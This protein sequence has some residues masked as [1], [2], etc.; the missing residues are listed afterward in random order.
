[1]NTHRTANLALKCL[2]VIFGIYSCDLDPAYTLYADANL[3]P[4]DN[5][6][7]WLFSGGWT[8][9]FCNFIFLISV[10]PENENR[11][12]TNMIYV[13]E[14]DDLTIQ[15]VLSRATGASHSP[16]P[17]SPLQNPTAS[18]ALSSRSKRATMS[19]PVR[20][21]K[22]A[23]TPAILRT[24]NGPRAISRKR[25]TTTSRPSLNVSRTFSPPPSSPAPGYVV[26]IHVGLNSRWTISSEN[27][28]NLL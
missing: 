21:N 18:S 13:D 9:D 27:N 5:I 19:A 14:S 11:R 17:A 12:L 23:S 6:I 15:V 2:E 26:Y 1:M 7:F 10:T 8:L 25:I 3:F 16:T 28:N 20:A 22:A 24:F 4:G